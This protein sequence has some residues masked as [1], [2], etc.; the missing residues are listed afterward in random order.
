LVPTAAGWR[1]DS[2]I[3]R[4]APEKF[5]ETPGGDTL[6]DV[7]KIFTPQVILFFVRVGAS[8]RRASTSWSIDARLFEG[9]RLIPRP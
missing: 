7:F 6:A 3:S 2:G 4:A 9:K 8:W 5:L 1:R